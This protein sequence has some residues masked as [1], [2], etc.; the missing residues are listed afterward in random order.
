VRFVLPAGYLFTAP[1]AGEDYEADSDADQLTGDSGV[2]D[3]PPGTDILDIDAG[4]IESAA[5]IK[6]TKT[7]VFHPGT[8]DPWAFC[9]VF[10]P[11][12][13]FN[14]L[15]FGDFTAAGGDTDGRL[16][17]GGN[18]DIPA[19]Y[20]VGIV[21]DGHPLP[22]Y[23]GGSTDIF[24]VGGNLNDG[25]WGV[26]GNI[27]YGGERTG[28]VRWMSNGN[29]LRKVTP[30]TFRN[31]GNVPSDGSGMTFDYLRDRLAERSALYASL[32]N[33]GVVSIDSSTWQLSSPDFRLTLFCCY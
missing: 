2:F 11:A 25:A 3:L 27:V 6:L 1:E 19:S 16:A 17:V 22:D 15:I 31:D 20:S 7:G 12:H 32:A 10:G 9:T 24:I 5:S 23:F 14:A 29:L 18:A 28:P 33:R 4:L 8:T 21:I 26:N 13:D 30:V